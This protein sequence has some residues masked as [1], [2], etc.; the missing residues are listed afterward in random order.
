M[1]RRTL[2]LFGLGIALFTILA[3]YLFSG[4]KTT[5]RG[6]YAA[7]E[8]FDNWEES[9]KI[10]EEKAQG[11]SL[12]N[13][14]LEYRTKHTS[15]LIDDKLDS[16]DL[17]GN[18]TTY[19]F[20]GKDFQLKTEEFDSIMAR[21]RAGSN[22]FLA[23]KGLSDNIYDYFFESSGYLWDYSEF[24]DV[25]ADKKSYR[26]NAVFQED[27][28]AIAWN[29]FPLDK[30]K[31]EE[32]YDLQQLR[33]LS[34]VKEY[35]NFLEF[36][37]GEGHVFL[38]S[39]PE[40]FQNYQLLSKNG[41][42][43]SKFVSEQV[44]E[45]HQVKWLEIGRFTYDDT[46]SDQYGD[47][48]SGGRDTSYLQFIFDN[49]A[50]TLALLITLL[51]IVLFL[52]FRTKRSQPV[53]P[54]IPKKGNQSLTFAETIK[55][56]YYK[57]QTP[58]SILLVMRRN[59]Y[60][61]VNKQ[62]FVDISK[63]DNEKEV[64]IL[65]DKSGVSMAHLQELLKLLRTKVASQ[66]DYAYLENASGLQQKFYLETGI[67]KHRLQ[68]KIEAR[69]RV[70]NRKM[71]LPVLLISA[72]IAILLYGF[73][74]LHKAEGVG[75]SLWPVGILV[76]AVGIRMFRTPLLK[77]EAGNLIFYRL[78]GRKHIVKADEIDRVYLEGNQSVFL[79][80]GKRRFTVSHSDLSAYDKQAYEQFIYPFINKRL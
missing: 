60:L 80:D 19:I 15:V 75:I 31:L 14:L 25:Y 11:I 30:I 53:I 32:N 46:Y 17:A 3:I 49:R 58:Y 4:G 68:Q 24:I 20:I 43:Y 71:L 23:Y 29:L 34:E 54:Y 76:T 79:A 65:A 78:L 21:V 52:V 50:L 55:E 59:F 62:F 6:T 40:V 18:K 2:L 10:E 39:N 51:G 12:F 38:H 74:L 7:A 44:P 63:E 48:G 8:V 67:I 16:A 26:L 42:A 69:E 35:S 56:I 47:E 27:T 73:Y 64:K 22:L 57:Q 5:A 72:G 70:F 77:V 61:A 45:D 13:E 66:V 28:I 37:I 1:P 41:Y 36:T 9:F 33:T